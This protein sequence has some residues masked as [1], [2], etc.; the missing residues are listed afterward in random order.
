MPP[1]LFMGERSNGQITQGD[2]AKYKSS[3]FHG[4]GSP[5][6]LAINQF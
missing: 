5:R 2:R 1:K 3:S 6:Y 4:V